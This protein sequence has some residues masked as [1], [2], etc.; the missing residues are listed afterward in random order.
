MA[1]IDFIKKIYI[2]VP[3]KIINFAAPV[4]YLIPDSIRYGS[5]FKN[6]KEFLETKEFLSENDQ[7]DLI[8]RKFV[9]LINYCYHNIPYYRELFDNNGLNVNMFNTVDDIK[10]IPFLTK[11]ILRERM[12]DLIALG[13]NKNE[14]L[15]LTTSGTTGTPLGIYV[16]RDNTMREWAYTLHLWKRVGYKP[17]SSR[18]V[19]RGKHFREEVRK[20]R[21]WQYD[22]LRRELS[23]NIHNMCEENLEEYCKAIERYK[24]EFVHGYPSAIYAL[25]LFIKKRALKHQF[26]GVLAV[27]ETIISEQRKIIEEVLNTRVFAFYGHSER[28]V[29]AGECELSNQYHVEPLYGIAEIVDESGKVI[30][31][32]SVGELVTTGFMNRSMP[33]LRYKTGDLAK[34]NKQ[35]RCECN[36]HTKLIEQVLG[37]KKEILVDKIGN[38]ILLTSLH[39]EFFE[40]NVRQLKFYQ[41]EIGKAKL[42]IIVDKKYSDKD[43]K[44]IL[45]ILKKDTRGSIDFEIEIVDEISA[46]LSGKR[47]IVIQKLD[48]RQWN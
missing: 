35:Q 22:A 30:I 47:E 13:A 45:K 41:D 3:I 31:D 37:R 15:L 19:L 26:K 42:L 9:E 6:Q 43:E 38:P 28:L 25:C 29:M 21:C 36:R 20:G 14:L 10:K 5:I 34:W 16:D 32:N 17:S 2:H 12:D 39:Y 18:L 46:K 27:S 4:Y 40:Q 44:S 1:F 48:T 33:L 11:D 24:P 23:C 8:N 7:A